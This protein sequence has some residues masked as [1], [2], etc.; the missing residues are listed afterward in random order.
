MTLGRVFAELP[1]SKKAKDA[2]EK[3]LNVIERVSKIDSM[4]EEGARPDKVT[5]DI[6]FNNVYFNYPNRS[7]LKILNGLNL[8]VKTGEVNALV[9]QSGCGKSTTIGIDKCIDKI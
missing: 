6:R 7:N 1:D 8:N 2:C 3:A 4:S 5:G 9:G